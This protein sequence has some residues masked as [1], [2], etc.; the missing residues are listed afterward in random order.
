M[1]LG[2]ILASM[3]KNE[4]AIRIFDEILQ[5]DPKNLQVLSSKGMTLMRM[6]KS[7]E[8]SQAFEQALKIDPKFHGAMEA[9]NQ[10]DQML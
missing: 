6:G 2:L 1:F 3:N 8:A 7:H 5:Q 9:K 4:D 10:I